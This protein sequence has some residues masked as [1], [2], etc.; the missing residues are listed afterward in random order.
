MKKTVDAGK[1]RLTP[2][3]RFPEFRGEPGWEEYRFSDLYA[4]GPTNTL[5]R[6]KLNYEA[7][8]VRNIH[9]GDIHT[10]FQTLFDIAKEVVPFANPSE[11]THGPES[12][13]LC[14]EGDMIFA[15]ASEDLEDVGK[16][17][18]IVALHGES[19]LSGTHTLF[20]RRKG[21][22]PVLGFGGHL[23]RSERIRKQIRKEAQGAKVYQISAKRLA[24]INVCLPSSPAEQRRIADCLSSLDELTAA[25][26]QK[27]D[28]LRAYKKGLLQQLF[29]RE[30]E[31]VPRLRFPE[32]QGKP[33]WETT[34]LGERA[35]ILKGRGISKADLDPTGAQACIRYGELYTRYAEIIREAVSRT[36]VPATELFLSKPGDVII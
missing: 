9:Y 29:P 30:G 27:L 23:F 24:G 7:G 3:L 17:I 14:A 36:K 20:A 32:F 6:D 31:T 22:S 12:M 1:K 25:H 34:K 2:K 15:D 35:A 26:A 21:S 19:L 5:S 33:G 4:D 16:S 8:N 18:E 13:C 11:I 28:S 10:R